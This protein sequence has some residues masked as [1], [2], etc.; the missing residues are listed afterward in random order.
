MNR[1]IAWVSLLGL[2]TVLLTVSACA[3]FLLS[4]QGNAFLAGFVNQE[5]LAL[6]GVIVTITLASAGNLHLEL[7]KLEDRT[8]LPFSRTR[9]A[10]R[11]SAYSLIMIFA[12]A[13][14]LVV[15]KPMLGSDI[16]ATAAANSVAIVLVVFSLFVLTDLTR[17]VLAIPAARTLPEAKDDKPKASPRRRKSGGIRE[18]AGQDKP[19]G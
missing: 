2:L 5:L 19:T 8:G 15:V 7:N 13:G 6:M 11:M 16:R 17:T 9:T 12:L 18:A 14:A 3:P 10:V 4:D 1:T